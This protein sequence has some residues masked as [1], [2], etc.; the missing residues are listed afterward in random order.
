M[1][2]YD[3]MLAQA[4]ELFLGYDQDDMIRCWSLDHDDDYLYVEYMTE[5]LRIDRHTAGVSYARQPAPGE[6]RASG[7]VNE[8]MALFDLLTRSPVRPRPAGRWTSISTLG[9]IIGAGHDR[10]LSH[11]GTA[12][13]FQGRC[14]ALAAACRRLGG[15]ATGKADVG[16]AIP[17]FR[18]FRILF[19]FWDG[20]DEFPA[21]IKYLFDENALQFMHYET[22]WYVMRTL[23]D[24]LAFYSDSR[25]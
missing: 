14:D 2:N 3:K 19:Q 8:G 9:G 10:T 15:V 13:Q 16:Y 5:A 17:V 11:E 18:N 21:N 7:F 24:R 22:L 1:S 20:D 23:A 12:A 6:Y 4:Q 25:H